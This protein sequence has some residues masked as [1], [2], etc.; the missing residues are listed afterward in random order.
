M[1]KCEI[2]N[3]DTC[4]LYNFNK[5]LET[6]KHKKKL[7][8][9]NKSVNKTSPIVKDKKQCICRYCD[10]EC[11]TPSNR[12]RHEKTCV[13]NNISNNIHNNTTEN[14]TNNNT[15]NHGKMIN[16]ELKKAMEMIKFLSTKLDKVTEMAINKPT[17]VHNTL[18]YVIKNYTKAEELK[19]LPTY[20]G[21][22]TDRIEPKETITINDI[23]FEEEITDPVELNRL[24]V[25]TLIMFKNMKT[26]HSILGEFLVRHYKKE[27][28]SLQSL[29]VT[30]SS[31]LK[32]IYV[33]LN[34]G[35]KEI[36]W[37][38]DPKGVNI[39]R[40]IID[41]LFCH[42]REQIKMYRTRLGEKF[43]QYPLLIK[44]REYDNM[45]DSCVLLAMLSDENNR[46]KDYNLKQKIIEY[47]APYFEF[48]KSI[49]YEEC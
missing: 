22:L 12:S 10:L 34:N 20:T 19:P 43:E 35:L 40:I 2:C 44:P 38:I 37:V 18:N 1:Y 7:L 11:S 46:K 8:A 28:K 5:H 16:Y 39:G 26:L 17:S 21:L 41:P 27:D 9:I 23:D 47:I 48:K 14:N 36:E 32:F 49:L 15:S 33:T 29:H 3:Y 25:E 13:K 4:K 30:D 31:R 24:F 42:M 6:T 45:E